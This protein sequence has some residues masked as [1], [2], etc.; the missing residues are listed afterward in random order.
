VAAAIFALS[1][2]G[3]AFSTTLA[4]FVAM[5]FCAGIG[6]GMASMLSPLYIAEVSP[7]AIR[8]RNVA[9]NQLTIVMGILVTNIINYFLAAK[10]IDAWRW[11]FGLGVVP[12]L[13]FLAGVLFLPESPRW[14]IN[15][16]R[17]TEATKILDRIGSA[18]YVSETLAA[19]GKITPVAGSTGYRAVFAKAVRP[20]VIVG[21][22]LA[23]FQQFCGI[24]VVFNYTAIIFESVGADLK[25]QLFQ[26]VAIGIVNLLFALL[27]VWQV[28]RL[29]RRPLMLM[30]S[31]GLAIV[32]VVLAVLL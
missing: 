11:M 26:M 3:M 21:I 17:L 23:V 5:R 22:T 27:A 7:A 18:R 2:L 1:S 8:G 6:V 20:A 14:L 30:G 12:S 13:F 32:Y 25:G 4:A 16:G 29:G 19:L 31:L 28:D 10:G 24:N 15:A 9:L